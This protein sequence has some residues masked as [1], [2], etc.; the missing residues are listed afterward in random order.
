MAREERQKQTAPG[1][2]YCW[3]A[4]SFPA[5]LAIGTSVKDSRVVFASY[6]LLQECVAQ[7]LFS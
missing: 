3:S 7:S 5:A 1:L 6:L 4:V 2:S